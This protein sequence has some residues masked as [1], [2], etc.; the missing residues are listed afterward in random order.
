MTTLKEEAQVYFRRGVHCMRPF[1][2]L[3]CQSRREG[4]VEGSQ[5][6]LRWTVS[7]VLSPA[8]ATFQG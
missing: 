3:P 8:G 7:A 6:A 1:P 5:M 4:A 2:R